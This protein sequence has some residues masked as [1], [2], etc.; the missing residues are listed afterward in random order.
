MAQFCEDHL[1]MRLADAQD[2]PDDRALQL[3][4]KLAPGHARSG[5]RNIEDQNM[6]SLL[7]DYSDF[8]KKPS[9][10]FVS[11]KKLKDSRGK[12]RVFSEILTSFP[13]CKLAP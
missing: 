7:E 13:R 3:Y 11:S 4:R 12:S 1:Q 10:L 9:A 5:V 2:G 8:D 6:V